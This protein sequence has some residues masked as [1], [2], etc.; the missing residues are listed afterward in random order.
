MECVKVCVYLERFKSYP[1]RYIRQIYNNETILIGSHGETNR[2]INSCSLCGLCGVVCPNDVCMAPICME[3]RTGLIK[4]GKM[5]PSAHDFALGDM[6]SSNSEKS[7]LALPDPGK[8]TSAYLFFPGCQLTAASPDHVVSAYGWLRSR[9]EGG[10]GLMLRCCGAPARWA[11]RDDLFGAS[12]TA[13][14]A[15]W[16]TL[17]KP[18]IIAACPTCYQVLKETLHGAEITTLWHVLA[19]GEIPGAAAG[20]SGTFVVHD[21]CTTRYEPEIH[22]AVRTILSRAGCGIEEPALSEET[23]ECCGFGGL[24]SSANPALAR[25][26]AKRRASREEGDY[27]TYCAM[28]RMALAGSGKKV[29]HLLDILFGAPADNRVPGLSERR[30]NRHRLKERLVKELWGKGDGKME[31]YEAIVLRISPEVLQVMEGR[32]ILKEDVQKVIDHGEKAGTRL[33]NPDTG[34]WLSFAR[35]GHVTYWVEYGPEGDGFRVV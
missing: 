19:S 27:L 26:V 29:I 24:M 23:T 9:M 4:R 35:P 2:L 25:E 34:H 30:E 15:D 21:P 20:A 6:E 8:E 32:N 1:K 10:V 16:E 33:V 28:C 13:L 18:A 31:D 22:K 5:P 3:G 7:A 14:K 11:A 17:G 12:L